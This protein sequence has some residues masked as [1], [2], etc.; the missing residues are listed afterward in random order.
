MCVCIY[1]A[2]ARLQQTKKKQHFIFYSIP[3]EGNLRM[4]I[5]ANEFL[6]DEELFLKKSI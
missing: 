4:K 3:N 1:L 2:L 5:R 6:F